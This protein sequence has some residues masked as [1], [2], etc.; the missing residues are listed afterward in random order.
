MIEQG[1]CEE[2]GPGGQFGGEAEP[3]DAGKAAGATGVHQL[4]RRCP[5]RAQSCGDRIQ[6]SGEALTKL[7]QG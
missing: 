3:R 5:R 6:N 7:A 4:Q 2:A 1:R